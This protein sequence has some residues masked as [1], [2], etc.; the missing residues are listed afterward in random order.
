MDIVDFLV[1]RDEL[2][3]DCGLFDVP[4][5]A[6]GVD[7]T[8]ADEVGQLGVPVEGSQR[9]REVIVLGAK[10]TTFFRFSSRET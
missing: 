9:R 2:G 10:Q 8:G 5:G 4:D 1:V 3:E 7:G 6:G